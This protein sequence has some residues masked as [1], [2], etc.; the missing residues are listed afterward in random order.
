MNIDLFNSLSQFF[1]EIAKKLG[2]FCCGS[3]GLTVIVTA[4][5]LLFYIKKKRQKKIE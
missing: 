3:I 1:G 5:V 4:I 2:S